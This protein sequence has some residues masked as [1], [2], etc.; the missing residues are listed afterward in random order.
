MAASP[1]SSESSWSATPTRAGDGRQAASQPRARLCLPK[2]WQKG[3]AATTI[4][5]CHCFCRWGLGPMA[6]KKKQLVAAGKL[7]K[8]GRPTEATPKVRRRWCS[9]GKG[10]SLR[11][12]GRRTS[13][14]KPIELVQEYL[15]ALGE[16]GGSRGAAEAGAAEQTTADEVRMPGTLSRQIFCLSPTSLGRSWLSLL[17]ACSC[18]LKVQ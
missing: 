15:R 4:V 2:A 18:I 3:S 1:K 7:D 6:Q 8:F 17:A 16:D 13:Y 5:Q 12:L 9:S 14:N 11:L 10:G